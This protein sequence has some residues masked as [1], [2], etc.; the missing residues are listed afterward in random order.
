MN[1]LNDPWAPEEC[2]LAQWISFQEEEMTGSESS[3]TWILHWSPSSSFRLTEI[4]FI[5]RTEFTWA[6][7]H[8][9]VSLCIQAVFFSV[10]YKC[11]IVC[12]ISMIRLVYR[13]LSP[14]HHSLIITWLEFFRL[15][16][17]VTDY[18]YGLLSIQWK[19][20]GFNVVLDP[21]GLHWMDQ[22]S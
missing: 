14:K 19:S 21:I 12:Q 1:E 6:C 3:E 15:W 18:L 9:S 16:G 22:N 10:F 8:E 5:S 4:L 20:V 17:N 11:H 13:G 7:A 2:K